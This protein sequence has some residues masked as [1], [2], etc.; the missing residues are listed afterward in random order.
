MLDSGKIFMYNI[1]VIKNSD[2]FKKGE[3]Y[4]FI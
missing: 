2:I 1:F 3:F 4:A